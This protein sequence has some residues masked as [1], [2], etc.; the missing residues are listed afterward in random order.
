MHAETR[1]GS[2][3]G[4]TELT[5]PELKAFLGI[6]I[7]MGVTQLPRLH[8]Y[9][10]TNYYLGAPHIVQAL[11]RDRY[12]RILRELHFNDNSTAIPRGQPGHDRAHKVRPV[13]DSILQKCLTLYKPH[14]EN[15]V[16]EAMVK[17]KGRSSL[18]QYMP[19]KPIKRGF[20]VWCRCDS[21]NGFTCSFQVYLGATDSVEKDLGIRATLDVTRD[22]FNKGFQI[23]CDNF[24]A[25]PQL[26]ACLEKEKTY[27]IGTVKKGRIGFTQFS[28][29][30]IKAMKRGEDISNVEFIEIKERL[31]ADVNPPSVVHVDAS[32]G[33]DSDDEVSSISSNDEDGPSGSN[34]V[35]DPSSSVPSSSTSDESSSH[36]PIH[37]FCWKDRKHVFFVNNVT[38]P[39]EV[40]TVVRKQKDGSNKSYPCPQ[41]VDL[42]NK[43]MGGVDMAD[44]MRRV[45]SCSRK[46]KHKWY[47]RLFWFLVDTSVVNAYILE[48]ESPNHRPAQSSGSRRKVH[49]SQLDF[50]LELGQQLVES[51]SSHKNL[52]RQPLIPRSESHYTLHVPCRYEKPQNCKVCSTKT[53][54]KQTQYGCVECGV[55]L[56]IAPCSGT[57]H[58]R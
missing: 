3:K 16:D 51:H 9:W 13:L 6:T 17:F 38:N 14:K 52:G 57:Y 53:S 33:D 10:S 1:E 46:S 41:S 50:V 43:Y 25:C 15:S 28:K 54:R 45:Y 22:V 24:F 39:R 29:T 47:M 42:Y 31:S 5:V 4:W 37:C 11:P 8:C 49:R 21:H 35:V 32:P 18:K 19:K 12:L 34:A 2:L 20:K 26:A 56:Y 7:L 36:Y 27:C 55:P 58:T 48:G 40:T 30:Q 23:Y 44:A